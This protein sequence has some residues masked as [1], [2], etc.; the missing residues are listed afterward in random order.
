MSSIQG[1]LLLA[2]VL[3]MNLR[4][5]KIA[6]RVLASVCLFSLPLAVLF[7]FNL[8]QL[9]EKVAFARGELHGDRFQ[10]PAVRLVNAVADYRAAAL[11][12]ASDA[13]ALK[14]NVSKLI[15]ELG[16]VDRELG[17][18]L[19]FTPAALKESG[20]ESAGAAAIAS[21]WEALQ[22]FAQ[23]D[24]KAASDCFDELM[25][26]LRTWIGHAGD[27][28]NLTLDPEMDSYYLADVTS[29]A[30]AQT[31][32]RIGSAKVTFESVLANGKLS[33]ADRISLAVVAAELKDS[34]FDRITGDLD[35][36]VKE[37]AKSARGVS[38]TL[39]AG[40][41][42]SV[43]QYKSAVQALID[44]LG[45][46][47]RTK[48]VNREE[49]RQAVDRASQA[50][51]D[52]WAATLRELD[53]VLQMR[54][55]GF[56]RYRTKLV[57]TTLLSLALAM[58]VLIATVRSVTNPLKEAVVH[59]EH[60]AEGDL[61]RDLSQSLLDRSDEIGALAQAMQTMSR[62]LRGM[63]AEVS[64]GVGDLSSTAA[65]LRGKSAGMAAES[66]SVSDRAHSVAAATGQMSSNVV[67]VAASMEQTTVNLTHVTHAIG[68][69]TETVNEISG[70][71][72]KARR[73]AAEAN[74]QSL[75]VTDKIRC[76]SE[77]A[78]AIG[79]VTQTITEI[80]SQTNL[81]ALNATIEAA[82]AGAAGK[83][84]GV[85][86]NEIKALAQQTA[87]ATED[88]KSR[89]A[90]VQNSTSGGI[91][92]IDKVSEIVREVNEIVSLIA[93]AIEEQSIT[94]KDIARNIAE[95]SAGVNDANRQ[96]A[97]SSHV[98]KEIARDIGTVDHAASEMA[99]GSRHMG[100]SAED[101][102]RISDLLQL[103][104]GKFRI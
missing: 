60:V 42:P 28:S 94:T 13:G 78:E 15:T 63:I 18:N 31:L 20:V 27:T 49:F 95:A 64:R 89:I 82:R 37:N 32:N 12:H 1:I 22:G 26:G 4:R 55:D 48:S 92:E 54:I 17:P 51:L 58:F 101:V 96:I 21:R 99:D 23:P 59:L 3:P 104:V 65:Q 30:I 46:A 35:T 9:S 70:N 97:Q 61:S 33:P 79:K 56:S 6:Q 98:S 102:F 41:E 50:S 24:S 52:L 66:S 29:V 71:T 53:V 72:E 103:T 62:Q 5:L 38:P 47:G 84:F 73:I 14:E 80:S 45:A 10:S 34:D 8:D 69:V 85:V 88:V 86:A 90:D 25:A 43:A 67:S 87:A 81:L 40:I 100:K 93:I 19:G 68:Q 2:R 57:L 36:A 77:A 7:Y 83:G 39:K 75:R 11:L 91:V 74:V 44:L 76:L 16:T